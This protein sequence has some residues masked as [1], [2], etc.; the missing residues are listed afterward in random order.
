MRVKTCRH[1]AGTQVKDQV[2][3]LLD[4]ILLQ[5]WDNPQDAFGFCSLDYYGSSSRILFS[6]HQ[7]IARRKM[8][9]RPRPRLRGRD[10]PWGS[11][12]QAA[13]VSVEMRWLKV[14]TA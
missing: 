8:K 13:R 10:A 12:S 2:C 14:A 9:L 7:E 4:L 6:F 11:R 1:A 5:F 3:S